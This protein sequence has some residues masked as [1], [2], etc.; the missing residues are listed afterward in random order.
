M[1]TGTS[2][3]ISTDTRFMLFSVWFKLTAAGYDTARELGPTLGG[4]FGYMRITTGNLFEIRYEQI[5][6]AEA[7]L[8]QNATSLRNEDPHHLLVS[9]DLNAATPFI[10]IYLDDVADTGTP[11]T[12]TQLT[13]SEFIDWSRPQCG[14]WS[15]NGAPDSSSFDGG[16]AEYWWHNSAALDLSVEANRRKFRDADGFPVDLGSDGSTPL[17]VQPFFYFHLDPAQTAE[18]YR[19]VNLGSAGGSWTQ[20]NG[21]LATSAWSPS[22]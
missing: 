5:G 16:Q 7:V 15:S 9:F 8:C 6:G 18:D 3:V 12:L 20:H 2:N 10:H 13:G 4:G 1:R 21:P 11:T 17:G 14:I 19:D 22:D